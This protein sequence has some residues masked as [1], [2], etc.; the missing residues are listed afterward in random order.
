MLYTYLKCGCIRQ[1]T[2]YQKPTKFRSGFRDPRP[3]LRKFYLPH[4]VHVDEKIYQQ[5]CHET[6]SYFRDI[7]HSLRPYHFNDRLSDLDMKTSA[8]LFYRRLGYKTKHDVLHDDKGLRRL[9]YAVHRIKTG[10]DKEPAKYKTVVTVADAKYDAV[11]CKTKARVV[12]VYP[13]EICAAENMFFA[14][15]RDHLPDDWVPTPAKYHYRF[16]GR[17]SASADYSNFDS[18][19]PSRIIRDAF[20]IIRSWFDFSRYNGGA[21]PYSA[22][23]LE[24]LWAF[25]VE[26]FIYTPHLLPDSTDTI[27]VKYHGVPSGSM[28][29]NVVDTICSR[30]ITTYLHRVNHCKASVTTYGDDV[31]FRDCTCQPSKL[32]TAADLA[33]GMKL[34]IMPGN[35]HGCLTY[36]KSECHKSKPY[37]EGIWYRNILN[38]CHKKFLGAV[39][40]CLM[41]TEPTRIQMRALRNVTRSHPPNKNEYF[42][43]WRQKF[44]EFWPKF[45]NSV[46]GL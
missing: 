9:R 26:Y 15:I 40:E 24:R 18:T 12:W 25:L 10:M 23:S 1:P 33:F 8:G 7:F 20:R 27:R 28:F 30:I 17:R 37:H 19:V 43:K 39:A 32:E 4:D 34:K 16:C 42:I 46:S 44:F 35:E 5:A 11:A 13:I 38:T 31:H 6:E 36:C 29:T 14:A 45:K 41:Y 2:L 22:T 21:I 3:I